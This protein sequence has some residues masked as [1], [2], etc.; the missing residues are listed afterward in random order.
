MYGSAPVVWRAVV[1]P[2]LPLQCTISPLGYCLASTRVWHVSVSI[3]QPACQRS[4]RFIERRRQILPVHFVVLFVQEQKCDYFKK[5]KWQCVQTSHAPV[6]AKKY[7][8]SGVSFQNSNNCIFYHY[9]CLPFKLNGPP[10]QQR[11]RFR[12][13]HQMALQCICR[14]HSIRSAQLDA[15]LF[16]PTRK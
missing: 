2:S 9:F 14:T 13:T 11:S 7:C 8:E 5:F 10:E 4:R 12:L 6:C 15:S 3:T 1:Y 16:F